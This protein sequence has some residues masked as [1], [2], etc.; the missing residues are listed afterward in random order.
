MTGL[1]LRSMKTVAVPL[2]P[3]L[4]FLLV[5]T[6]STA[7]AAASDPFPL[8][9]GLSGDEALRL[10]ERIYREGILPSGEPLM[11]Y[12]EGDIPVTGTQFSCV[13]CHLRSGIGS[14]EGGIVTPP[15]N[16]L[17]LSQPLYYYSELTP[18]ER[19]KIPWF[20]EHPAQRPAY[21]EAK[22]AAALLG[23]LDPSG[24]VLDFIMPRYHLHDRDMAILIYY[25]KSLST[26]YPPGVTD[27][28]IRFA[29]VITDDVSPQDR[30]AMLK[31]LENYIRGRNSRYRSHSIMAKA[32]VFADEMDLSYRRLELDRWVLKGAPETWRS[33]LEDY[34]RK[35]P[36]FALL[37][38]ISNGDWRPIH[39]FSE[40]HR[41]PCIFPITSLPVISDSDW[42]TLYFS[43]GVYQEGES[44][45]RYLARVADLPKDG[46]VVL[47]VQDTVRA[48]AV[49]EAF[50]KT[51]HDLGRTSAVTRTLPE[52]KAALRDFFL[53]LI[54]TE[55]PAVILLWAGTEALPALEALAGNPDRPGTVIVSAG[56]MKQSIWEIPEAVRDNTYITYPEQIPQGSA[57]AAKTLP[58]VSA[59]D[60][61]EAN[62]VFYLSSLMTD[63][64]MMMKRNY[65][66]DYFLDLISM[67]KDMV[68]PYHPRISFGPNQRY[69]SK[70]CFIVQLTHGANPG[71]VKKSEWVI[72]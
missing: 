54:A 2:L 41:I 55:K 3:V 7:S 61:T 53:T 46:T 16:W 69:A 58:G 28:T 42:Y 35:G 30:E 45:A 60:R 24:R 18:A 33:Q 23:G 64:L 6:V 63:T 65:Y 8:P 50:Q 66:R 44:A 38:G 71:L 26:T 15:T 31:P 49:A 52:G 56:L 59:D 4:L 43:K 51:W 27:N 11:A 12:V 17:K 39:E 29:T 67:M 68:Y 1:M 20:F 48:R 37:G 9:A 72:H 21:T 22:V 47:V 25:L 10:G 32:K 19:G 40:D 62:T 57:K 70:G 34:Y 36:V 14:F 5:W 13:S